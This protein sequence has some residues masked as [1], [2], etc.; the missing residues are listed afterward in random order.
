MHKIIFL[1]GASGVGK[2]FLVNFMENKY[3]NNSKILFLHF[4]SIGVPSIEKMHTDF[5]GPENW[6]KQMTFNWIERITSPVYKEKKIVFEGQMNIS[7]IIEG[8]KQQKH[9]DYKIFLITCD[10]NTMSDRLL[11]NRNQPG[12]FTRQMINW[13]T[14]LNNQASEFNVSILDTS[15]LS[16]VQCSEIVELEIF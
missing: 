13:L 16:V 8:F 3:K 12:L 4:D 1:T 14:F 6:Q 15:K 2:T 10:A 7:F 9:E 5:G 11:N